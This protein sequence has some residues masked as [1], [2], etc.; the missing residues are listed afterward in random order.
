MLTS[1]DHLYY[2]GPGDV[3]SWYGLFS[4]MPT[5]VAQTLN[6]EFNLVMWLLF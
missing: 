2:M 4:V 1:L 3:P 6:L 5:E